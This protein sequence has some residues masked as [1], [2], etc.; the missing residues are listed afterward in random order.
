M[1]QEDPSKFLT[2]AK[3]VQSDLDLTPVKK[4]GVSEETNS[5]FNELKTKT[6][7]TAKR[8]KSDDDLFSKYFK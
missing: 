1:R 4:R 5:I 3:L 7:K 8:K 2:I 6:K